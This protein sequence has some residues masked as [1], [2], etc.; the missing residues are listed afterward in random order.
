MKK[1]L[2]FSDIH[3]NTSWAL[4][5]ELEAMKEIV[6]TAKPDVILIAGDV[7]EASVQFNPYKQLSNF[8]VPVVFCLGNHEF[9]YRSVEETLDFYRKFYDPDKYDVHCLDIVGNHQIDDLN[10][11]GNVLWYDGS[12]KDI[13]RQSDVKIYDGWLDSTIR[14]FDFH[15][16]NEKCVKQIMEGYKPGM[17][18]FLL[19]HCCPDISLNEHVKNGPSL[20]NYYSGMNLLKKLEDENMPLTM[21]VCGHTHKY[22]SVMTHGVLAV[23]IGNDYYFRTHNMKH[24]MFYV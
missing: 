15:K 5:P 6:K 7:F 23:N 9:A 8:G 2:A 1:V 16:E 12:F 21:A 17:K 3:T 14:N 4:S 19:T 22:S 18:N 10:F 24:M 13:P 11:I 20:A